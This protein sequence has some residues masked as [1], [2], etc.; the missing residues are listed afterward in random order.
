MRAS[1]ALSCIGWVSEGLLIWLAMLW[2]H[3]L[4]VCF[5]VVQSQAQEAKVLPGW[6]SDSVILSMDRRPL[7]CRF[8]KGQPMLRL[9]TIGS[10]SIISTRISPIGFGSGLLVLTPRRK[11]QCTLLQHKGPMWLSVF[12]YDRAG[13]QESSRAFV[14]TA[15]PAPGPASS[16]TV[17]GS[18]GG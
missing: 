18:E 12:R 13:G 17:A 9:S 8:P 1:R 15:S 4:N 3:T 5:L 7:S 14:L 2:A 16:N 6:G 11:G 10:P